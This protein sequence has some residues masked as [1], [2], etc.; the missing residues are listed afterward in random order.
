MSWGAVCTCSA[1]ASFLHLL[2]FSRPTG[3]AVVTTDAKLASQMYRGSA[4]A[5]IARA[6]CVL[7]WLPFLWGAGCA[8]QT[9]NIYSFG[10]LRF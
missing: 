7:L 1:R 2:T 4:R 9:A 8:R 6:I 3:Q 10:I 5:A